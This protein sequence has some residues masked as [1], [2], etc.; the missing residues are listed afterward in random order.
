MPCK[1]SVP[2]TVV[3]YWAGDVGSIGKWW[4]NWNDNVN[5]FKN[6]GYLVEEYSGSSGSTS[7]HYGSVLKSSAGKSNLYGTY[8]WGHGNQ[9]GLANSNDPH[10]LLVFSGFS[11]PYQIAFAHIYACESNSG[12]SAFNSI[13]WTGFTGTLYPINPFDTDWD[14]PSN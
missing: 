8:F 4:I 11:L 7:G 6:E 10:Y 3:V 1:V 14:N 9:K 12:E 13:I 2:N 5:N